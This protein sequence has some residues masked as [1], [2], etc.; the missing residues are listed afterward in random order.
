MRTA[1]AVEGTATERLYL[2][3]LKNNLLA[4]GVGLH[5]QLLVTWIARLFG[6]PWPRIDFS[7]R[8]ANG[9]ALHDRAANRF[10]R[11]VVA[12]PSQWAVGANST[13]AHVV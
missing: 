10:Q 8:R 5:S 13:G 4:I 1:I 12:V 9:T 6:R 3:F 2:I 7:G 11:I